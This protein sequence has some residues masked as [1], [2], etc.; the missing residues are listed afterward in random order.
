MTALDKLGIAKSLKLRRKIEFLCDAS[1]FPA[2][3]SGGRW[4]IA[5]RWKKSSVLQIPG[6]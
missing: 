4:R 5:K 3:R 6:G 1:L 2:S